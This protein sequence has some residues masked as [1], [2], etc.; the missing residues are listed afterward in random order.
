[1]RD[2][3]VYL[4]SPRG[5]CAGVERAIRTVEEALA[6]HGRPVYVRHEIV[7]N[8]HVVDRLKAMGAV[9]IE[10]AGE[11]PPD[12]PVIFSAHGAPRAAHAAAEARSR[13]VIDATCPLVQKVHSEIRRHVARGRHVV[14]IGHRGH[15]EVEGAVGQVRPGAV[16]II[17]TAAEARALSP[18]PVPL[19]FATQTTLSIDDAAGIAAIL[20]ERFS[21]IEGPRTADICYATQN[22]QNAVK[23]IAPRCEHLLVIG[24]PTSSN[25]QRLVEVA[26]AAGAAFAELVDDPGAYDFGRLAGCVRIGLTSGASV[27]EDLIETFLAQLALRRPIIVET[28]ETAREDVVF[29]RPLIAAE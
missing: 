1:M 2:L 4:A 19:A 8:R 12:R 6:A 20:K 9:F 18:P 16:T 24:S 25:S 10:D 13:I 15:P 22:R 21:D 5:F 17:E 7:H 3:I 23:A 28:I 11:A 29:K 26:R 14:L 27:P